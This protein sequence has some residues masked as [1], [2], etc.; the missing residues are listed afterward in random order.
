MNRCI[1]MRI[2]EDYLSPLKTSAI[3]WA[4][5]VSVSEELLW[6]GCLHLIFSLSSSPVI[7]AWVQLGN[8]LLQVGDAKI[9][10]PPLLSI[11]ASYQNMS[12][13]WLPL[14][15]GMF[16]P[17]AGREGEWPLYVSPGRRDLKPS[18]EQRTLNTQEKS[19][20]DE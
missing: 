19:S 14:G 13:H 20:G 6:N 12:W 16:L 17:V 4:T 1:S 18:S 9:Y 7:H 2:G 5:L 8:C 11:M 3:L 15:W 10:S